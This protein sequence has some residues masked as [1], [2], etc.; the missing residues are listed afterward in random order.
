MKIQYSH[1]YLQIFF[2][3]FNEKNHESKVISAHFFKA[4][5]TQITML[6]R[7]FKKKKLMIKKIKLRW[8]RDFY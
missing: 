7:H 8:S 1:D 4:D 6:Y 5:R 3:F 2:E